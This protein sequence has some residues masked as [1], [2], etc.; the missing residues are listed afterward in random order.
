MRIIHTSDWHLG[1]QFGP[2]SLQSDQ[3]AFIDWFVDL[4]ADQQADLVVIAGDLYDRAVAPN[5]A[6][7]M[8]SDAVRRLL[9]VGAKVA[10]ITGNHDGAARVAPYDDL[11]DRSGFILR[12][13]YEGV[14][15]VLRHE[16]ADGPLDLVMLP[17]LDPQSAP[18]D[19]G[20]EHDADPGTAT[21]LLERRRRRTH[22]SVLQAAVAAVDARRAAAPATRS[23][24][25]AHAFVTGGE[26]SDSE[27]RLVV[28]GT[29]DVDATVFAGF[30]Y[31][32]LGHLHRPQTVGGPTLRYSGTP[33]AYSFS[34]THP[35]EVVVVDMAADG[36]CRVTGVPVG[37]GRSVC[38][39]TGTIADLLDP[40]RHPEATAK[41][42]RAIVTDR[43]TV[44]DA[45]ARLAAVYPNV[46]EVRLL[47]SG[48]HVALEDAP[49]DVRELSPLDA[50]RQ[51]WEAAEGTP[52]D[53]DID[54]L[55]IDAVNEATN[56]VDA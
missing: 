53:P 10:A 44:L 33:L 45:K 9:S 4:V 3:A 6:I 48:E 54:A 5:E 56:K 38:T 37:V 32:A 21:D 11:L 15:R 25:V 18:D 41:F 13:G 27:R 40:Q 30:S 7:E 2:V 12:G 26:P 39:I 20:L 35:K 24:A 31:T 43:E 16:F 17:F 22:H 55:L 42:V 46:I 28:G 34:E 23:L 1:V 8:F 50:T 49:L 14:G 47:P 36:S 29:S 52:P 19:F 51:F